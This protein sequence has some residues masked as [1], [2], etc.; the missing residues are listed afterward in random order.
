MS[1]DQ[2]KSKR[3]L[4]S[5]LILLALFMACNK[6]P[7][8]QDPAYLDA[9]QVLRSQFPGVAVITTNFTMNREKIEVERADKNY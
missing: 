4:S 7:E 2:T 3:K 8:F 1:I 6:E 9:N 5:L